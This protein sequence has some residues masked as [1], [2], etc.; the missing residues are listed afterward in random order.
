[1]SPLLQK[2]R[3]PPTPDTPTSSDQP[4]PNRSPQ[5]WFRPANNPSLSN[6]ARTQHPHRTL[7]FSSIRELAR[8]SSRQ[9]LRTL[10]TIEN[11]QPY[12]HGCSP[13]KDEKPRH[14]KAANDPES[15]LPS[16]SDLQ[17][18][19]DS[20]VESLPIDHSGFSNDSTYATTPSPA[21][22][23]AFQLL[24]TSSPVQLKSMGNKASTVLRS[25]IPLDGKPSSETITT[26][27]EN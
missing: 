7:G 16:D 27:S 20:S 19:R 10:P 21:K 12:L 6:L 9:T 2:R 13:P 22:H 26:D 8:S 3:P 24:E 11:Q 14:L 23:R 25:S 18:S 15:S 5:S 4:T 1:M 17:Q